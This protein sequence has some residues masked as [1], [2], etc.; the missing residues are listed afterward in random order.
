MQR[1]VARS[2]RGSTRNL[3]HSEG[4]AVELKALKRPRDERVARWI[5]CKVT[6]ANGLGLAWLAWQACMHRVKVDR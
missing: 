6:V 4:Q 2:T 5:A 3:M 1:E